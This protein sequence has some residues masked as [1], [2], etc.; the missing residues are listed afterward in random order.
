MRFGR[1]ILKA[2]CGYQNPAT[3]QCNVKCSSALCEPMGGILQVSSYALVVMYCL[4][5]GYI[6]STAL[7]FLFMHLP[8]EKN[9]YLFFY[10]H[11]NQATFIFR[12]VLVD[13]IAAESA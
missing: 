3:W 4:T 9:I 7:V 13:R 5:H 8:P 2:V 6:K 1:D 10:C 11:V 12:V